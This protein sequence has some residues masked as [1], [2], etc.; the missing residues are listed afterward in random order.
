MKEQELRN[1]LVEI[2]NKMDMEDLEGVIIN[3]YEEGASNKEA[4]EEIK[5]VFFRTFPAYR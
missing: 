4:A 1:A 3:M 5:E 2:L